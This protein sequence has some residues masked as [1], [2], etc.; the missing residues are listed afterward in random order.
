V[1]QSTVFDSESK[2]LII[3]KSDVK[4]KN[5]KYTSEVNLRNIQPSQISKIHKATDDALDDSIGGLEAGNIKLKE[6]IKELE[7][8]LMPLPLLSSHLE[9]IRP[10][11]PTTKIKGPSSLLTFSR[12]YVENNIKKRMELITKAWEISKSIVSFGSRAHA[13]LEYL[14]ADLKN[15][16]CF[17]IDS[18]VPFGIKITNMSE[19]KRREVGLPSPSRIKQ[20]KSCWKEKINKFNN[21]I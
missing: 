8:T 15:E 21:I 2:K 5:G 13:F 14:Q 17:Y 3:E 19:L 9:I 11:T 18:V 7:E 4:N 1:F 6:R 12:S 16:S 20:L 10:T